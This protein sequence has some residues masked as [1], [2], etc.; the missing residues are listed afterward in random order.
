MEAGRKTPLIETVQMTREES[1]HFYRTFAKRLYNIS[2]RI[3]QDPSL[4]E[5]IMQ[6]T[7]LKEIRFLDKSEGLA[8]RAAGRKVGDMPEGSQKLGEYPAA[9]RSIGAWLAKTCIRASIDEL[10]KRKRERLF[11]EE[12]SA[13]EENGCFEQ[14]E[15]IPQDGSEEA[16]FD[17]SKIMEAISRLKDPYR[18]VL[19]LVLIE[20]LDYEEISSMTGE[21]EGTL[22]TQ[23]SRARK[24]LAALLKETN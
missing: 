6:D 20:G 14:T 12:Y 2:L 8:P 18:L 16:L 5:E 21:R 10:R 15:G 13:M 3:V 17:V 19:N 24:M 11:L 22:R 4:A 1:I 23:Y 7:V 9:G